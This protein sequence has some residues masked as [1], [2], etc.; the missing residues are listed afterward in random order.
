MLSHK[1]YHFVPFLVPSVVVRTRTR[2]RNREPWSVPGKVL[3][4]STGR[5]WTGAGT[6]E[7]TYKVTSTG[8]QR[9]GDGQPIPGT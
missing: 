3:Q 4:T 5:G 9:G 7:P 1:L 8:E 6:E 2:R